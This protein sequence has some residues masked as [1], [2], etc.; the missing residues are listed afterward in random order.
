MAFCFK[1]QQIFC[2]YLWCEV[3]SVTYRQLLGA[4]RHSRLYFCFPRSTSL[5]T[6]T[7]RAVWIIVKIIW[8]YQH[9]S[10]LLK[11]MKSRLV[12]YKLPVP[13]SPFKKRKSY[14]LQNGKRDTSLFWLIRYETKNGF[15][16]ASCKD[17][18]SFR[19]VDSFAE[20]ACFGVCMQTTV[21]FTD[22]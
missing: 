3:N 16:M 2:V 10:D 1:W 6:E 7:W 21:S 4:T 14:R 13:S 22:V 19:R 20:V 9:C 12:C 15:S 11:W 17:A 18:L 8:E 5:I